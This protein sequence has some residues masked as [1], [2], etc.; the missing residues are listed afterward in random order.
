MTASRFTLAV[1]EV[2]VVAI[3]RGL[4]AGAAV[5]V[6]CAA[7]D[8]G[9]L[10]VEVT[11]DS[12]GAVEAIAGLVAAVPT[13]VAVGAGTVLSAA[14]V[15]LAV[16]AGAAFLVAPHLD[17]EVMARAVAAGV[18][19]VPG[20]AS[21]TELHTAVRAGA[22]MVKL[23]PAG[24]LGPG[25]VAALRGPYPDVPIMVSGGVTVDAVQAWLR[26]GATVA[27]IGLSSLGRAAPE[28]GE[29]ARTLVELLA[30][31]D[32]AP[33]RGAAPARPAA[34]ALWRAGHRRSHPGGS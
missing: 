25:Y 5:S 18:P 17:A 10:A 29:R 21:P 4:P 31:A 3:L 13:E 12:P 30:G 22:T 20:V 19:V 28:V 8:G 1:A 11:L 32:R 27:G 6:G 23:F 7:V 26:A 15:D 16:A 14:D 2:P 33:G 9:L 24:P 34:P